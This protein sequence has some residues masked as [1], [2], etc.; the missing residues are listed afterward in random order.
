MPAFGMDPAKPWPAP[1]KLTAMGQIKSQFEGVLDERI[2]Q[3]LNVS[4]REL[5]SLSYGESKLA[6]ICP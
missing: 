1:G 3:T 2:Q 6:L 4:R 5:E